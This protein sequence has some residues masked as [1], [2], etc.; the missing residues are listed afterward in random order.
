MGERSRKMQVLLG[1]GPQRIMI[2]DDKSKRITCAH[3]LVH[4]KRWD[5][6]ALRGKDKLRVSHN[7]KGVPHLI[8]RLTTGGVG[9]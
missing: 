6:I 1:I 7:S 4:L 2:L 3:R 5:I 9:G 8:L